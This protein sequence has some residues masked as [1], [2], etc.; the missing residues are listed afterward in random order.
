[1]ESKDINQMDTELKELLDGAEDE[2]EPPQIIFKGCR[3]KIVIVGKLRGHVDKGLD[4][5]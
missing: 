4:L 3:V 1:M 5:D 2:E